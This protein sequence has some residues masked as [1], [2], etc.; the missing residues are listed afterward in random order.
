MEKFYELITVPIAPGWG[1]GRR[2]TDEPEPGKK[3]DKW[4]RQFWFYFSLFH[5]II[6][7]QQTKL[8]FPNQV[9]FTYDSNW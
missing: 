7:C 2:V 8:I 6:N 4:R 5:S 9:C 3:G 1:G